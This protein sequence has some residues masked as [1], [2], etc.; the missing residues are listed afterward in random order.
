MARHHNMYF[1]VFGKRSSKIN[2]IFGLSSGNVSLLATVAIDL[3]AIL[4]ARNEFVRMREEGPETQNRL[5]LF[6]AAIQIR[7]STRGF[8]SVSAYRENF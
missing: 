7:G 8:S 5:F 3:P 1:N 2:Y 6:S 4:A